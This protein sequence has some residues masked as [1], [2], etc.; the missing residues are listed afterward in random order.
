MIIKKTL[1]FFF[2]FSIFVF[3]QH[4]VSIGSKLG[5]GTIKSNSPSQGSYFFSFFI[6]V[7]TPFSNAIVSRFSFIYGQDLDELLPNNSDAYHSFVRGVSVS[8]VITQNLK[9]NFY[10]EES[11]GLLAL[12][13]RI[14]SNNSV[15]DYGAVFSI[16]GGLDLRS[17]SKEGF[18]IGL[19]VENGFT[20]SNTL[21]KYFTIYFQA[22]IFL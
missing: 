14:F 20:F 16:L 21:A 15:W 13:D 22:Q 10:L 17:K 1:L 11:A 8:A 5:G 4:S 18:R 7:P 2:L 6:D 9:N 19:G 12:N 3:A